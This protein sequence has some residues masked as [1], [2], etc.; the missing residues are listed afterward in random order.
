[1][2]LILVWPGERYLPSYVDALTRGWSPDNMREIEA[3]KEE[4]AAI[5]T[6]SHSFLASLVDRDAAGPPITLLDGSTAPR[7]PGYHRWMWDGDLCGS[8][9]FRWQPGTTA[10]PPYCLG[11]IGYS[12]VPW[13]RNRG[14]ATAALRLFLPEARQEGLAFVELTTDRSNVAS[15]RV[16]EACGGQLVETFVKPAQLGGSEGLRY[17]I[18]LT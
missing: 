16:I 12:V 8:I 15:C 1:M 2:S 17:R 6:D 11:H 7:L 3:A 18:S 13:K 9:G 4:L 14:Y 5:A 10:L